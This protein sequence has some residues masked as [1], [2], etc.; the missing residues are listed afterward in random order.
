MNLEKT[1]DLAYYE[2]L[3]YTFVIRKDEEGD[4]VGRIQELPGCISHGPTEASAIENLR[5]MQRLW[6]ED[7]LTEGDA[8]PEPENLSTMPSGKWVQRVP[9]KLHKDLVR[10]AEQENVSLNQL[11]TSMLSEQIAVKS[12]LQVVRACVADA[13]TTHIAHPPSL[14]WQAWDE[15]PEEP[16]LWIGASHVLHT[17]I[18]KA[19]TRVKK[20]APPWP[21]ESA[22]KTPRQQYV[23]LD[24]EESYI[25]EHATHQ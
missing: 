16:Q 3:P 10:L 18:A 12:C 7:A 17:G 11:V 6:L 14:M 8:I 24:P 2:A 22:H 13:F 9:R 20:L 4:F 21:K 15:N 25:D 23:L 1:K 19:I 5:A